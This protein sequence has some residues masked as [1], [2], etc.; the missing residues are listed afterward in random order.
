MISN[1]IVSGMTCDHCVRAVSEEVAAVEGVHDVQ[2]DL[3]SGAL[4]VTSTEPVDLAVIESAVD[5]AGD[6]TV[7]AA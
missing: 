4:T 3:T 6:Y 5:E 7:A 1:Y 2:V